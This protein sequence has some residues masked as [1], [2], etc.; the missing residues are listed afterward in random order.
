M[1]SYSVTPSQEPSPI[2]NLFFVV[3]ALELSSS[4]WQPAS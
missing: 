3:Q 4:P 1:I 2:V